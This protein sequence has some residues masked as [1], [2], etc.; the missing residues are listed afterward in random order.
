MEVATVMIEKILLPGVASAEAFDDAPEADMFPAEQAVIAHAIDSRR[1]EFGTVRR[2]ARQALAELGIPAVPLLPGEGR[3]PRWPDGVVG[4]M[5][6]CAGYRAAAV[7]RSPAT[8]A[9][10]IDAEPNEPLPEGILQVISLDEE[11]ARLAELATR[12]VGHADIGH[13]DVGHG[14]VV[15]WDRLLFC[16][17]EAVYKAWYPLARRWLDFESALVSIDP[18]GSFTARLLVSGPQVGGTELEGFSGRWLAAGGLLLATIALQSV[19]MVE[20]ASAGPHAG[21]E[22]A[23]RIKLAHHHGDMPPAG[24]DVSAAALHAGTSAQLHPRLG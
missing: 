5:T 24:A 4:S 16:C 15:N 10:G 1:R 8:L 18:A 12:D 2:C 23:H 7:A 17:K 9:V 21:L 11:R 19:N 13:G 3:A 22:A 20:Q 6:H 14:D